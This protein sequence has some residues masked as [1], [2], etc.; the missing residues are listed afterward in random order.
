MQVEA[1]ANNSN[2][3]NWSLARERLKVQRLSLA[4]K[5]GIS[6]RDIVIVMTWCKSFFCS[7]GALPG[8]GEA[9]APETGGNSRNLRGGPTFALPSR[10]AS[11]AY[12]PQDLSKVTELDVNAYGQPTRRKPTARTSC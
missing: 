11:F 6:L 2:N 4:C 9:R 5:A 7:G 12:A 10:A 1:D 8:A 3:V